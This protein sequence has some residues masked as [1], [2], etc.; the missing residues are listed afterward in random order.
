[1]AS[2]CRLYIALKKTSTRG[3]K[4]INGPAWRFV[5]AGVRGPKGVRSEAEY[6][7]AGEAGSGPGRWRRRGGS[8]WARGML[9]LDAEGVGEWVG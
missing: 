6:N 2:G 9:A 4:R 3:W 8:S 7:P 5:F 1:M